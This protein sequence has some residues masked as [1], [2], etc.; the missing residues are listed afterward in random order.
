VTYFLAEHARI[1][2]EQKASW[3]FVSGPQK[4]GMFR[5][6]NKNALTTMYVRPIRQSQF[7]YGWIVQ[8]D[9]PIDPHFKNVLTPMNEEE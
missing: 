3:S 8:A 4:K 9:G 5:L 1:Y 7:R 2:E 6:F